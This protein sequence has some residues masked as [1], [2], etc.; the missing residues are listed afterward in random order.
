M[1]KRVRKK[2]AL[3]RQHPRYVG[4]SRKNPSGVTIVDQHIRRL[5][6]TFLTS[7]EIKD[8]AKKYERSSIPYPSKNDLG[9]RDGN[10][11]DDLV[12]VWTDYF[13]KKFSVRNIAEGKLKRAPTAEEV[14]LEYKGLSKSKSSYKESALQNFRKH[15]EALIQE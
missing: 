12:A 5:P 13:N 3:V 11:Y 15:Y 8:T 14:I 6:G 9:Y 7:D 2:I 1:M 10:K 4:V